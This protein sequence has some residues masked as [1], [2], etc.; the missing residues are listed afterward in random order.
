ML[1]L[2]H[3]L[4]SDFVVT[5]LFMHSLPG[6]ILLYLATPIFIPKVFLHEISSYSYN[7]FVSLSQDLVHWRHW[8]MV[9]LTFSQ[10]LSLLKERIIWWINLQLNFWCC[11]VIT[12]RK[13]LLKNQH[14]VNWHHRIHM[15]SISLVPP[16]WVHNNNIVLLHYTAIEN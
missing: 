9:V 14:H 16:M 5:S 10:S 11:D 8:V 2:G 4:I 1:S 15:W 3:I 12:C 13:N 6:M 7:S